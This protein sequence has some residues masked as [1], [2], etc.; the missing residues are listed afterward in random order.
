MS[1]VYCRSRRLV[2]HADMYLSHLLEA[3][4]VDVVV[5][6]ELDGRR[7]LNAASR[8]VDSVAWLCTTCQSRHRRRQRVTA[9]GRMLQ[10]VVYIVTHL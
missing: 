7:R 2:L 9:A 6:G 3:E 5:S 8:P 10:Q 4:S 1:D